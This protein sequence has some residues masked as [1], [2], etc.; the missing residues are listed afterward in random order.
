MKG[1]FIRELVNQN[2]PG[3]ASHPFS[4]P[5]ERPHSVSPQY[6]PPRLTIEKSVGTSLETVNFKPPT[7]GSLAQLLGK[8][9]VKTAFSDN[10]AIYSSNW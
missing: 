5:N 6:A 2:T 4:A 3:P 9:N 7:Q 1:A 10:G 8:S